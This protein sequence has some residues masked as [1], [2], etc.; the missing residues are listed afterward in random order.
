LLEF[1]Q[2]FSIIIICNILFVIWQNFVIFWQI[3]RTQ[4]GHPAQACL[5]TSYFN[6]CDVAVANSSYKNFPWF[7]WRALVPS[8]FEKGYLPLLLPRV[9][10]NW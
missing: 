8:Q 4:F 9:F 1:W 7:S 6:A 5:M 3:R 10:L 2:Y